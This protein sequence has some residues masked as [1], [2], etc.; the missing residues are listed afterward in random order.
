MLE[1]ALWAGL[2]TGMD[3]AHGMA[4][5]DFTAE[6]RRLWTGLLENMLLGGRPH[7]RTH[8]RAWQAGAPRRVS[9][10]RSARLRRRPVQACSR[11]SLRTAGRSASAATV[12]WCCRFMGKERRR[13]SKGTPAAMPL[14]LSRSASRSC[15]QA[16][17][18]ALF[19]A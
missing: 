10:L 16:H 11:A 8:L 6:H 13:P 12:S 17:R 14:Q 7:A 3:W 1:S 15:A 4:G 18:D 19:R 9:R 2:G 5:A